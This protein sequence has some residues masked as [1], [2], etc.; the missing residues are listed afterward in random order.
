M[1]RREANPTRLLEG[2]NRQ[3]DRQARLKRRGLAGPVEKRYAVPVPET[4][5]AA[6]Q[7]SGD[8][9]SFQ[10][11]CLPP[12]NRDLTPSVRHD[13]IWA[14]RFSIRRSI[15]FQIKLDTI[16]LDYFKPVTN[17]YN[18]AVDKGM[19]SAEG[20]VEIALQFKSL[21]L[22]SA[23]VDGIQVDY[24]QTP[25][26]AGAAKEATRETLK[27]A[28]Q[29][30]TRAYSSGSTGSTS[31]RAI[32]GSSTRPRPRTIGSSGRYHGDADEPQ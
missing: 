32:S 16:A 29:A 24:I 15:A 6:G 31:S 14:S 3:S 30:R 4:S 12:G 21:K 26:K 10:S 28:D 7:A 17:R 27:A 18:L 23:T 13:L 1:E 11:A 8:P 20:E 22:W 19:L 2:I 9:A 25:A 5:P